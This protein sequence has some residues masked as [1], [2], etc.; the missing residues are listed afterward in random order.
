MSL[1][2]EVHCRLEE[3][4][5]ETTKSIPENCKRKETW[6][7]IKNMV[8][9]IN[10]DVKPYLITIKKKEYVNNVA[11]KDENRK[12]KMYGQ[13]DVVHKGSEYWQR[14]LEFGYQKK[15]FTSFEMD[16]IGVAANMEARG[17]PPS[18]KQCVYILDA[19]KKALEH[20]FGLDD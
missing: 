5:R 2:Y 12:G 20:G 8:F 4:S 19:H 14:V 10:E 18:D 1:A 17:K 6:D 15:I 7:A 11:M 9:D 3:I 13:M 16:V